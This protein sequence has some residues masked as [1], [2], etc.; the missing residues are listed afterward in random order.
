MLLS[1]GRR[2]IWSGR[3]PAKMRVKRLIKSRYSWE[4]AHEPQLLAPRDRT[5]QQGMTIDA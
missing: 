2:A 3:V 5:E 4:L 1:S